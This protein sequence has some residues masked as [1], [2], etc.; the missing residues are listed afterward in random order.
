M[1]GIRDIFGELVPSLALL[2][3][4]NQWRQCVLLID[5]RAGYGLSAAGAVVTEVQAR[6]SGD[7]AW[8]NIV[9]APLDLSA[10]NNQQKTV[11]VRFRN[12]S[13]GE[14]YFNLTLAKV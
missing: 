2:G 4:S 7:I 9:S 3:E 8:Q 14:E 5:C 11:E 10:F 12:S 1:I 6:F 13:A